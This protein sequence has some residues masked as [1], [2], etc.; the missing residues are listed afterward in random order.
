MQ[1]R[2]QI[3]VRVILSGFFV[4]LA[5]IVATILVSQQEALASGDF[6]NKRAQSIDLA[7]LADTLYV[8]RGTVKVHYPTDSQSV[9]ERSEEVNLIRT[10]TEKAVYASSTGKELG[11]AY[12]TSKI[13]LD[14][15]ERRFVW[16]ADTRV[17]EVCFEDK[18]TPKGII[19]KVVPGEE[20]RAPAEGRILK[21]EIQKTGGYAVVLM[22]TADIVTTY[23]ALDDLNPA[24]EFDNKGK[25]TGS[26]LV[27]K[28]EM[29]GKV[30]KS[31]ATLLL[32]LDVLQVP[33]DP[34]LKAF[35]PAFLNFKKGS[36]CQK[37]SYSYAE[38]IKSHLI[39]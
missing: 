11:I 22:H 4:V 29:L 35:N 34:L 37:N 5:V 19:L 23:T 27:S 3:F 12:G 21:R 15:A 24:L 1:K 9:F 7:L 39:S 14:T 26:C 31:S 20:V 38:V 16:P 28:N 2:G 18:K 25:C 36:N 10:G 17:V 30:P 13:I 32:K 8:S 33:Q 6:L